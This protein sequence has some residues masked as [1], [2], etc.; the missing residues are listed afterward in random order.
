MTTTPVLKIE[1]DDSAFQAFQAALKKF[2]DDVNRAAPGLAP[3]AVAPGP[4][5]QV[6]PGGGSGHPGPGGGS[7]AVPSGHTPPPPP[8]A[9]PPV[10]TP[11]TAPR[12][13]A[14]GGVGQSPWG[15]AGRG[16]FGPGAPR[17][18]LPPGGAGW[19][20][21]GAANG[22]ATVFIINNTVANTQKQ[23]RQLNL[24]RR[25]A[26]SVVKPFRL[27]ARV[28]RRITK[29]IENGVKSLLR[30]ASIG[31][32]ASG[33]F[34]VLDI[35]GLR[36]LSNIA[37]DQAKAGA[38]A[39]V[40]QGQLTGFENAYS[41]FIDDPQGFLNNVANAR[42]D[43]EKQPGFVAL[44][45]GREFRD[46][47][48]SD[49]ELSKRSLDAAARKYVEVGGNLQAYTGLG[50]DKIVPY[51]TARMYAASSP[52]ERAETEALADAQARRGLSGKELSGWRDFTVKMNTLGTDI[53][54]IFMRAFGSLTGRL[55]RL[56]DAFTM[57]LNTLLLHTDVNK[58][59]GDFAKL[60]ERAAKS[61]ESG[62]FEKGVKDVI[63]WI[64]KTATKGIEFVE[65]LSSLV[66]SLGDT[67]DWFKSF[68]PKE[69]FG[70]P[71]P[72]D[73]GNSY[74]ET[75]PRNP[76][77]SPS[78]WTDPVGWGLKKLGIEDPAQKIYRE[79]FLKKENERNADAPLFSPTSGNYGAIG[80]YGPLM[81]ATQEQ[82]NNLPPGML[83]ALTGPETSFGA[84]PRSL[85]PSINPDGTVANAL[86]A[87]QITPSA[88][89][90]SRWGPAIPLDK[91]T[92]LPDEAEF[93]GRNVGWLYNNPASPAYHDASGAV[94]AY[95]MGDTGF[96][97]LKERAEANR[98]DW[99]DELREEATT[100]RKYLGQTVHQLDVV[101]D[102]WRGKITPPGTT[103]AALQAQVTIAINNATGG[104]VATTMNGNA[105]I[106]PGGSANVGGTAR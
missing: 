28:T 48:V 97:N 106:G 6:A 84:D 21:G 13:W 73:P 60:I 65:T 87:F 77:Y 16:G 98:R 18:P 80:S 66:K 72:N 17:P 82:R 7:S 35:L 71:N 11:A 8:G 102:Y 69:Q 44:G 2:Q 99:K 68:L 31:G 85:K 42:L 55:G 57:F 19:A 95:N 58:W 49:Y 12:T 24:F 56:G 100:T 39:N 78:P 20:P 79:D 61:L 46:S 74:P 34:G 25:V 53:E 30:F 4:A 64:D 51:E 101:E 96:K 75:D 70:P 52:R 23:V 22:G 45:L 32:L 27:I 103:P 90:D 105:A 10:Q 33:A 41:K 62:D 37:T 94:V 54:N 47:R 83:F 26:N 38:R 67:V 9:P 43:Y 89:N 40:T 15:P 50:Y 92:Y 5:P 1:V 81:Y 29:N 3:G 63:S 36:H 14:P 104:Q 86:G 91:R 93:A 76:N 88:A 59:I